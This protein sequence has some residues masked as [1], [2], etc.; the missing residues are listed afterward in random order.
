M[1]I[2]SIP[3]I[4]IKYAIVNTNGSKIQLKKSNLKELND[5]LLI[6]KLQPFR[7][8]EIRKQQYG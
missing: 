8:F 5:E 4:Y 3:T 2:H 1:L 6:D 7:V